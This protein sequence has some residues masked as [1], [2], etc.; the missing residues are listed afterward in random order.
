MSNTTSIFS[1]DHGQKKLNKAIGVEESYL[2]ELQEQAANVLKDYL[3]DENKNMRDDLSPSLLVEKCLH[4]F[5]YNQLV[6]MSSFFLQNKIEDF[7]N[8]LE[9]SLTKM[10]KTVKSISLNEE[11]V[12]PHIKEAL[13]KFMKDGKGIDSSSAING[14]DLPKEIRDFLD[15]I[16]KR[17][18]GDGDDD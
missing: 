10:Q 15:D 16:T 12:P 18:D 1:F 8:K 4:E 14:E 5:S 13:L 3:F 17:Q 9:N 11:D 6:I 2:D 7:A